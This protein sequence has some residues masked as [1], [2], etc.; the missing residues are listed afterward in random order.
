LGKALRSKEAAHEIVQDIMRV[1]HELGRIPSRDT[2]LKHGKFSQH[3]IILHFGS[4]TT[5]M[6]ASG[7]EYTKGK[8]DKQEI[9]KEAF[10]HL[11]KEVE[12]RKSLVTPPPICKNIFF[13]SD[14]H[15]PYQHPDAI[16][17]IIAISRKYKFDKIILS[18]DEVD[19]HAMSFHDTDEDLPSAGHELDAAIKAL[20]PLYKE[21]PVADICSSN[22]GDMVYRKG[23]HHGFP[24]HVLKS[25]RDVLK[26]PPGW[27][28]HFEIK[29]QLS[30]GKFCL[31][32]HSYAGPVLLNSKKRG[33]S[34]LC[35]HVH[36][37]LAVEV[38]ENAD[39][40]FFAGNAGCLIDDKSMAYAYNKDIVERPALGCIRITDGIPYLIPMVRDKHGR[41]NGIVP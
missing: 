6:K 30:D 34:L 36:N 23:K 31:F 37:R 7:L 24:R 14:I 12:E 18:G 15:A 8:P 1:A 19:F 5:M 32:N 3:D 13:I 21:F 22:H 28:W 38:W 25:Y 9:R 16:D 4:W 17:F 26:A 40:T 20:E 35:G 29:V 11:K 33:I 41:W 10:K 2:Y 39:Q 27:N